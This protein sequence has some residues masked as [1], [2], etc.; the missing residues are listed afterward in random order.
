MWRIFPIHL[1]LIIIS[2]IFNIE[3]VYSFVGSG[4]H[5]LNRVGSLLYSTPPR[6]PRRMLKKVGPEFVLRFRTV[7]NR[8]DLKCTFFLFLC[9]S[10]FLFF[11]QRRRRQRNGQK[12]EAGENFAWDTAESRPLV[13]S[14]A[15]EGTFVVLKWV[16]YQLKWNTYTKTKI[17]WFAIDYSRTRLLDWSKRTWKRKNPWRSHQ[18]SKINGRR[19]SKGKTESGDCSSLQTGKHRI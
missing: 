4:G 6:Q 19:S 7:S 16:E 18:E 13:A 15:K 14:V 8:F 17:V 12:I 3:E 9:K 10:L 1:I 2:L 11:L 5:Q